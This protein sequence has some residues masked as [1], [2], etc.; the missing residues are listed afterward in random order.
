MSDRL[1]TKKQI[2]EIIE[3]KLGIKVTLHKGLKQYANEADYECSYPI[4]GLKNS[5]IHA[6]TSS[7]E[8]DVYIVFDN[9]VYKEGS[10]GGIYS[11]SKKHYIQLTSWEKLP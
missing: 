1:L 11:D 6:E 8:V 7:G 2:E 4:W 3:M 9:P 5:R 10:D